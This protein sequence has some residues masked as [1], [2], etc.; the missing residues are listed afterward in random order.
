M[1]KYYIG[2]LA[3]CV[4]VLGLTGYT[5]IQS[6]AAKQ[7]VQTEKKAREIATKLN[8]YVRQNQEIPESLNEAGVSDAPKTVRYS[9]K[10]DKEYEFCVT[11]KSAKTYGY[12][13]P[14]TLLT[15]SI[16][17]DLGTE[18]SYDDYYGGSSYKPSTLYLSY[19]Y[20]KGENCQTVQPYFY[21]S[22]N[23]RGSTSTAS[24]AAQDTERKTDINTLHAQLEVYYN[25]HGKYPS[26]SELNSSTWRSTNMKGLDREALRDPAGSSY[27]LLSNAF[28]NYYSYTAKSD[29]G[30]TCSTTLA[31]T[32]YT[33]TATLSDSTAHTK[34]SLN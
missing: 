14:E 17:R 13:G 9:K 7:D 33:L 16:T 3:L 2:I 24:K 4:L 20:K 5:L 21:T 26:L 11:Y 32:S 19:T 10:S 1:K 30:S 8:D 31:C 23:S 12:S 34:Q 15:G 27:T 28:K 18:E 29:S 25:D 6:A 22:Y